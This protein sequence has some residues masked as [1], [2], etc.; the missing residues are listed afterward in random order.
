VSLVLDASAT[1]AW[2]FDDE[3]TADSE[4]LIDRVASEGASVPLIWLYE[5]ANGLFS[6]VRRKRIDSA[7]REASLAEL[8]LF[9][10]TVDRDGAEGAAWTSTLALAARFALT[11]YDAAYVEL[12]Q[13]RGLSLAT[14]DRAMRR[15]AAT[16]GIGLLG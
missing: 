7:Y 10:I 4:Q 16:L 11:V 1:L 3:R 12:A 13:R 15:A 14:G 8:K 9:D 6:A 5:V 2:F